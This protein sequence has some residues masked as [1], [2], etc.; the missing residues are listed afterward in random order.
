MEQACLI[1]LEMIAR[2]KTSQTRRCAKICGTTLTATVIE[3]MTTTIV[4]GT[5]FVLETY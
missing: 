3:C 5:I 4:L 1:Y 2:W